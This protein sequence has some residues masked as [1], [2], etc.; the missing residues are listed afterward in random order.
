VLFIE[1]LRRFNASA[2]SWP[3]PETLTDTALEEHLF[4]KSQKPQENIPLPDISFIQSEMLRP[5][6]TL[7][8]LFEEYKAANPNGISRSSFFPLCQ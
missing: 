5:H 7:Q 1:T 4:P 3:L 8:R 6:V 2:L